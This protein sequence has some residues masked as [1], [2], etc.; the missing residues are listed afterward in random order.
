MVEFK[1]YLEDCTTYPPNCLSAFYMHPN[2]SNYAIEISVFNEHRFAFYYW[3]IWQ[4]KKKKTS[5]PSLVTFDWHQDLLSPEEC[6]KPDLRKLNIEDTFELTFYTTHKLRPLNDSHIL[7]AAYLDLIDDIYVLCKQGTFERDFDNEELIDRNGKK[8]IIRKFRDTKSLYES[9]QEN[10]VQEV[11]FDLD[12]DYFVKDCNLEFDVEVEHLSNK[13]IQNTIDCNSDL[14]KFIFERT[15][16]ITI[17]L[18]PKY[19]G[20]LNKSLELLNIVSSNWFTRPFGM[21]NSKWRHL[22][23]NSK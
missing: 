15:I 16:G 3:S 20:G 18:E 9:I 2:G 6:Q 13:E 14:I 8:H 22:A 7:S 4:N 12:L 23:D 10:N 19:T 11:F 1:P 17:A 5:T 21:N